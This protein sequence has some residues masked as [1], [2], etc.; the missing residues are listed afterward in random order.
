MKKNG[1]KLILL[2]IFVAAVL[3]ITGCAEKEHSYTI[4]LK[5]ESEMTLELGNQYI[6]PGY[7]ANDTVDGEV[8]RLVRIDGMVD[9]NEVGTYTL[10]YYIEEGKP[11]ATR[12]VHVVEAE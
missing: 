12:T 11:L 8:S 10:T 2:I 1:I 5:G 9:Y 4:T 3:V 6:E 7:E